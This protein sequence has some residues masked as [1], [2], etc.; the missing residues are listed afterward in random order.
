MLKRCELK[1]KNKAQTLLAL[2]GKLKNATVLPVVR[3]L[4]DD[5]V[6]NEDK[7]L[8]EILSKFDENLIVRSSASSE[9]NAVSS[10]AG[11]FL[12]VGNVSNNKADLKK[13][14]K[15]VANS[16]KNCE[17][18]DE[19]FVQPMLKNVSKCGVIFSADIDN[20]APYYIIN[21]D[22]SG[23]TDLITSG[24]AKDD[25]TF[26]CYKNYENIK[27]LSLKKL[28]NAVKEIEKLFD[29]ASLD[30]E[31][32]FC[33]DE[34][35]ILQ[36]REIVQ[37]SKENLSNINISDALFKIYKKFEKLNAPYPNLMGDE[38]IFGVMPD[39]NPAEIIG[40]KPK[41]LSTSLYKELITDEIWAYQRDNYGYRNL[42]SYPLMVSFMGL[43]YIDVRVSFNS[44]LPKHLNEKIAKKLVNF[45]IKKLKENKIYHD[46][47]EFEIIYSCYY[48]G[49]E[50]DLKELLKYGFNEQEIKR[51]EFSLLELTNFILQKNG[52]FE[53]DLQKIE[54]LKDKFESVINSDISIIDKIYWL[55]EDCKRYGTL[56]FAGIA[57]AAFI[58]VQFLNSLVYKNVL[59]K[60]E[61]NAFLNSLNT[62]SKQL[63]VDISKLNKDEFLKIYGHLRPGTYDICSNRYDEAYDSYFSGIS[64]PP[65]EIEFEFSKKQ[66]E[67]IS[68]LL[69]EYGINSSFDEFI[70]FI[71]LAI[72]GREYAKFIF[73][74]SLS[75]MLKFIEEL[76]A[77]FEIDKNDLA[78]LDFSVIKRLY[79]T[80]DELD[81]REIFLNNIQKNKKSYNLSKALK[82][83]ALIAQKDD[84]YNFFLEKNEPN[85]ITQKSVLGKISTI[86]SGDFENKIV[87]VESADPGYDFL[88]SKNI[89]AL[90]T[91]WGG[92]NSH[93]AIRCAEL[94]I[95]AVIG[96]GEA[97]FDKIAKANSVQIDAG[98]KKIK[99]I[100]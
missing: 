17:E 82:L 5:F 7:I 15:D 58:S 68:T 97:L 54:I 28:I 56:P 37:K 91:C 2:S 93:M 23:K 46:K 59:N 38:S 40:I 6:K 31:F 65:K 73:T 61:L 20:L 79:G 36:V 27:D 16:Y 39:W 47:I 14:I 49:I 71:K 22:E 43:C 53:K 44:F 55:C 34:I 8:N 9:D 86:Q 85:F 25:K 12:S 66:K 87:C 98:A 29:K 41:A 62:I 3:F 26:I 80:L 18:G 81:L 89:L 88:F 24:N 95:V 50:D 76:G 32:A 78:F 96:C 35:Y 19:I 30:I 4:V 90:V 11:E 63:S 75:Q 51:I 69:N 64:K 48:F 42:R 60:D 33:G 99:V 77:R 70:N 92:A 94:G 1:L 13:A 74:K 52:V 45:Y 21:Y 84:I 83:P 57:R 67:Q 100:S 10:K 72:E